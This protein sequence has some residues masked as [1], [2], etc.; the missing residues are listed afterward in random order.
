MCKIMIRAAVLFILCCGIFC[1]TGC[2]E[3][4]MSEEEIQAQ[5]QD[6]PGFYPEARLRIEDMAITKRQTDTKGKTDIVYVTVDADNDAV[7][8]TLS[9]ILSYVLYNEGWMLEDVE[10]DY[11][12]KWE[13]A[14]LEGPDLEVVQNYLV[15]ANYDNA[16]Y[17]S[18]E[19]NLESGTDTYTF[20][21]VT[22]YAYMTARDTLRVI[23]SFDEDSGTWMCDEDSVEIISTD[24]MWD[25]NGKWDY[26]W[27]VGMVD[28]KYTVTVTDFTDGVL[29][30]D[31]DL[32]SRGNFDYRAVGSGAFKME[33][34]G[35]NHPSFAYKMEIPSDNIHWDFELTVSK[36][37]GV[38]VDTHNLAKTSE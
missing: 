11:T 23:A 5:L 34:Y 9:Y 1:L 38:F 3:K 4:P 21:N 12:G 31:Y 28:L 22:N 33:G 24:T 14:P 37:G 18:N 6:S 20:T 35:K 17:V 15:S 7:T 8:C 32:F 13:I 2:S 16:E 30:C 26:S 25:L 10:R 29:T 27:K 36:D 19:A